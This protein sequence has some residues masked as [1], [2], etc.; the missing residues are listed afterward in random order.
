MTQPADVVEQGS[1]K[2][3]TEKS[4]E[5]RCDECGC[6]CTRGRDGTEYGHQRG[7]G[8]NNGRPRCP[9]RPD[10][11]DPTRSAPDPDGWIESDDGGDE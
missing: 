4:R 1:Y 8:T 11:V 5:F 10:G 3:D 6:R 9:R 2:L 7:S